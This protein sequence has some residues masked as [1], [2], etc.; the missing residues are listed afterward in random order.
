MDG[1]RCGRHSVV[2]AFVEMKVSTEQSFH[3]Q[4]VL[5]DVVSIPGLGTRVP[6][7]PNHDVPGMVFGPAALPVVVG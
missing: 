4:D 1:C 7:D 5:E 3:H 2:D 6:G